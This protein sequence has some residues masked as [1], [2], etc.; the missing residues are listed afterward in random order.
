[1]PFHII[2][3]RFDPKTE[4]FK[5]DDIHAFETNKHIRYK[6]VSFFE[7]DKEHYWSVFF[8]Y[9]ILSKHPD[10]DQKETEKLDDDQRPVYEKLKQW[11]NEAAQKEGIPPYMIAKNKDILFMVES[12]ITTHEALRQIKGFGDRKM[13]KYGQDILEILKRFYEETP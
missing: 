3:T 4:T 2:T 8:E 7:H 1:M 13:E 12:R 9:E 11:R 5:M 6:Q 10:K